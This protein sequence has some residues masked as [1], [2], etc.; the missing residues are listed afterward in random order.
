M[1]WT[2]TTAGRDACLTDGGLNALVIEGTTVANP[3]V[4][5]STTGGATELL[6][7]IMDTTDA[8][9]DNGDGTAIFQRPSAASWVNYQQNAIGTGDMAQF[10]LFNRDNVLVGSGTVT[11]VTGAGDWQFADSPGVG[12]TSGNPVQTN[13]PVVTQPSSV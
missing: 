13:A 7:I 4:K 9:L 6:N 3:Y 8:L 5:I 2:L 1:T 12:V 10:E 11:T